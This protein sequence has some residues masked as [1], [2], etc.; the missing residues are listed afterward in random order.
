MRFEQTHS[1]GLRQLYLTVSW[2]L[3]TLRD[4]PDGVLVSPKSGKQRMR[5]G[6]RV[7][8]R[9]GTETRESL[10]GTKEDSK[11]LMIPG[12][13]DDFFLSRTPKEKIEL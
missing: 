8:Q 2:D 11:L 5:Q 13:V 4:T 1:Q 6:L 9:S 12:Q 3:R 10:G 7:L